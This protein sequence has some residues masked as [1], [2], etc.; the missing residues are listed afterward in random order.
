MR[1]AQQVHLDETQ[2]EMRDRYQS[3][4]VARLED[5]LKTQAL[6]RDGYMS[7]L[8]G[9]VQ[10]YA[11]GHPH[12]DLVC[13]DANELYFQLLCMHVLIIRQTVMLLPQYAKA[14]FSD[15][16]YALIIAASRQLTS[17]PNYTQLAKLES[18]RVFWNFG[19]DCW[20]K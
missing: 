18:W 1:F 16:T 3:Y 7:P 12:S 10:R 13:R 4:Q 17:V 20:K 14:A 5:A 19:S 2:A 15:A 6:V 11:V 8:L 9:T